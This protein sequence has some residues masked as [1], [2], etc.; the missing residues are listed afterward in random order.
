MSVLGPGEAE[1]LDAV[2]V[3]VG[4]QPLDRAWV[5]VDADKAEQILAAILHRD[6][7]YKVELMPE[8][9]ARWLASTFLRGF[10]RHR[11]QFATNSEDMPHE[12][13]WSWTP[14]TD[15]TFDAGIV[16]LGEAAS[17]I[18]WVADED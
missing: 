12:M 4:L 17:G 2:A 14:A 16:I 8:H 9:T 10:D 18:Y 13:P 3:A 5:Q 1:D 11:S 7:A 6:L 15:A